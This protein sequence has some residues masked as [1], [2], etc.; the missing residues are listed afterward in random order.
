[1]A[2]SRHG[3]KKGFDAQSCYTETLANICLK[4]GRYERA[5]EI[6][7]YLHLNNPK[8]SAYFADKIR[9]IP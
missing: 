6:L 9:F 3:T 8:K 1:M 7:T 2:H 5:A 4:Q